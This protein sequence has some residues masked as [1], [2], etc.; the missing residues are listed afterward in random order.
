MATDIIAQLL[1]KWSV[2]I[3]IGSIALKTALVIVMATILGCERTTNLHTA[4]LRTLIVLSVGSLFAGIADIYFITSLGVK[5]PI[6]SAAVLIAVS[7]NTTNTIIFSSKNQIK[8]FTTS[9]GLW[10]MS[11]ISVLIGIGLYTAALIGFVVLMVGLLAFTKLEVVLK[12]KSNHFEVHLEL[13]SRNGLQEFIKIVREFR[14]KIENI[15]L[16]P[17]FANSGLAVYSV[18]FFIKSND[19]KKKSHEDIIKV[20]SALDCV[21]FIEII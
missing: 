5:F 12:N 13:K 11:I 18:K 10:T 16:N 21:S 8:G 6:M 15:E 14:L 20:L 7:I 2:E 3:N 9:M 17:A 4:G 1:G 19:L